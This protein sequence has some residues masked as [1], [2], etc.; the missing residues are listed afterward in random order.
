MN[1]NHKSKAN[2]LEIVLRTIKESSARNRERTLETLSVAKSAPTRSRSENG[3]S[4]LTDLE[5]GILRRKCYEKLLDRRR[6]GVFSAFYCGRDRDLC[7]KSITPVFFELIQHLKAHGA[8]ESGIFRRE[9]SRAV[10]KQVVERLAANSPLDYGRYSILELASALKSYIRDYLDGFFD[11]KL[12]GKIF[13]SIGQSDSE[14]TDML[15]RYL[16]F[17]LGPTQRKCLLGI[18]ELLLAIDRNKSSSRMSLD[19]LCNIF[20]LTMTPQEMFKE[21]R[22]IPDAVVFLKALMRIDMEDVSAVRRSLCM[23]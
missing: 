5:K 6:S 12:L 4:R 21:L 10:Y 3:F 23:L 22:V 1:T 14:Q 16:I 8:S 19:S 15:C 2:K 7:K 9:G 18:Q 20:C 11:P 17:S 13:K